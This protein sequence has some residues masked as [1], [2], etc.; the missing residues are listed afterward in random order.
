LGCV[1][2][3]TDHRYLTAELVR[4]IRESAWLFVY[5]VNTLE[6]AQVLF[7]WG[8]DALCTDRIDLI[9]PDFERAGRGSSI[10]GR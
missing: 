8:V 6:R 1:A 9:P 4:E 3:H 10:T 2:L 7:D 5:T